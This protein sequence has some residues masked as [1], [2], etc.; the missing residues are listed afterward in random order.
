M[1]QTKEEYADNA[2]AVFFGKVLHIG[3]G[4]SDNGTIGDDNFRV[5]MRIRTVYKGKNVTRLTT[6]RTNE[7]GA[8]CGYESFEEGSRFT[9]F[10]DK[11]N[12]KFF[13]HLCSGTKRGNINP[14]N[15]GLPEGYEPED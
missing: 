4:D 3:G 14:D 13:T 11:R 1:E 12:G 7:S 9:V 5:K 6:V 2:D 8:A 10:A 15:Y